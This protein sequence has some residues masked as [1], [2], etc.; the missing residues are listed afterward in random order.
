MCNMNRKK[1]IK[2]INGK[3]YCF[4]KSIKASSKFF[5]LFLFE[6]KYIKFFLSILKIFSKN[7][8]NTFNDLIF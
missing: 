1:K 5:H 8:A 4:N 3:T 6:L 2:K 7:L